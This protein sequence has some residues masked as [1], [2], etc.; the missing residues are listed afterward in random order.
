MS[1]YNSS[2]N[3]NNSNNNSSSDDSD[4]ED[5]TTLK[6]QKN[7]AIQLVPSR[8]NEYTHDNYGQSFIANYDT[9]KVLDGVVLQRDDKPGTWKVFSAGKFF[10][11]NPEDGLVYENFDEEDGYSG[12]MSAQDVLDASR[13]DGFSESAGGKTYYYTPVGV[14]IEEDDDIAVNDDVDVNV[15]AENA[16]DVGSASML[17]NNNSWVRTF[18]K[19]IT[20]E[21][22]GIIN[23]NGMDPTPRGEPDDNPKYGSHEWLTTQDPTLRSELEG[24]EIE[25]WVT[26]QTTTFDDGETNTYR[27]P[28]VMDSKTGEFVEIDND[29]S[30]SGSTS[31]QK[32][33]AT[34]GGTMT[35]DTSDSS[36]TESPDSP[37]ASPDGLPENV[38]DKLDDLIDYMARNDKTDPDQIRDF[39]EDEVENADQIDWDAAAVE[40]E[41]RAE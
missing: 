14:V 26:E 38:P 41:R 4:Y 8:L 15:T 33:A 27:V 10:N 36:S 22:D 1:R 30:D 31:E 32:A 20:A 35:Q 16:I 17:L 6:I 40:A 12:R 13:V 11:L 24:R 9:A 2:Q 29:E 3:G 37:S 18:A 19:K 21:G 25:L 39:A 7:C 28:N 5:D 34:D 23:D